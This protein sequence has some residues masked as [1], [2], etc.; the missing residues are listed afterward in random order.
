MSKFCNYG[1]VPADVLYV[2]VVPLLMWL[3][4]M[5][6]VIIHGNCTGGGKDKYVSFQFFFNLNKET[7]KQY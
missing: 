6:K 7:L 2:C 1:C 4:V 5:L 3:R